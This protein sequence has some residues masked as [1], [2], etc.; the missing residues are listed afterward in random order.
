M[1]VLL[2]SNINMQPLVQFLNPWDVTVGEFNSLILDLS[3]P[4]SLA[5]S[6]E[7]SH[8]LCLYDT[9]SLLGEALYGEGTPEQCEFYLEALELFCLAQAGKVVITNTFCVSSARWLNFADLTHEA[10]LRSL[11]NHL[12]ERLLQ[13][14]KK[15]SNLIVIDIE[16]LFRLYGEQALLSNAFWYM[17][18]IRYSNQMLRVL[19]NRVQQAVRAYSSQCRKVLILD[20]D[21][22]LWGGIVGEV[23]PLGIDLSNDGKGWCFRDFQRVLRALRKTGVL[24]AIA[25][26]NN[27][28]D[29]DEVFQK[30]PMMVLQ[31]EDFACI[32]AN[33]EPKPCN[34][35]EIAAT[36][37]LGVNSLVFIDDNPAERELVVTSLPEVAVPEFP[38]RVEELSP[39]FLREVAPTYFGKTRITSEDVRKTEQYRA[40]EERRQLSVSLDL[41]AFL[42]NLRIECKLQ[43]DPGDQ[44]ARI[45]QLTQKTNQFNL[46][47]RRYQI[48]EIEFFLNSPAHAV[49]LL[50]YSDRFGFEGAVGLVILNY[51][52]CRIDSLLMSCRV[53]GRHV[54]DRLLDK[55]CELLRSRGCGRIVGEFIST[56]K[57]QQVASF[58]DSHGFVVLAEY[59]GR[60]L[61]E[62]VMNGR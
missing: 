60:R 10:S 5:Q 8:I 32:R 59:E 42:E 11:E 18:R 26:K 1:K 13:L 62:K 19:A 39:W 44:V 30:N 53:I 23:G 35:L 9:D 37:N 55:A 48:P 41:D 27:A 56:P 31:R 14:T 40:N 17:G 2:L 49:V 6:P 15:H 46:T 36:L 51:K 34:I 12:N 22:T 24:L 54:E 61:Y 33:W 4:S 47:T 3:N 29:I 7:Y 43:V 16:L 28:A 21:N 57:N 25:S 38:A 50:E 58:Y 45:A 52:E 20:L